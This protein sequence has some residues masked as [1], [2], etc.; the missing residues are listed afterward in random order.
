MAEGGQAETKIGICI[1]LYNQV[2]SIFFKSFVNFFV[3]L[4]QKYPTRLFTVDST[5]VDVARNVLVE[6]FLQSD[7]SHLLFLDS[8]MVLPANVLDVLLG[9]GKD[10]VS[11]LYVL[12]KVHRPCYRFFKDGHYRA[13]EKIEPNKLLEVDAV[14]LGCCLIKRAV[15]ERLS[16]EHPQKPLFRMDYRGRTEVLGEDAFFCELVRRAGFKIFVDTSVLVGHFGGI[17]PEGAFKGVVY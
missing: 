15:L 7:C 6:N 12:R 11:A 1:P 9:R 5:A 14:G 10:M 3:S 16:R 2:P 17:I 13:P 4:A 8:D